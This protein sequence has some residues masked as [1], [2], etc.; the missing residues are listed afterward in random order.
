M[1]TI[2]RIAMD[3]C[4]HARWW[5]VY[6]YYYYRCVLCVVRVYIARSRIRLTDRLA[7]TESTAESTCWNLRGMAWW[8]WAR[9]WC[10]Q[11]PAAGKPPCSANIFYAHPTRAVERTERAIWSSRVSW[12]RARNTPLPASYVRARS[13]F[14]ETCP[15]TDH[16][17]INVNNRLVTLRLL[18][19]ANEKIKKC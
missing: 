6:Y 14:R 3:H 8:W 19:C 9:R 12:A 7:R 5:V 15:D 1:H 18:P 2:L 13:G 11:R 17:W 16:K 10:I 4:M